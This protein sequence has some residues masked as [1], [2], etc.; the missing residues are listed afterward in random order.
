MFWI[1]V[2]C[3]GV[4]G[5]LADIILGEWSK[6]FSLSTWFASIPMYLV[7]MTGL[8]IVIRIG[9]TDGFQLTIAVLLVVLLNIAGL[10]LWDSY[11][12]SPLSVMQW[13]GVVLGLAAVACFE[14]GRA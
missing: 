4:I 5:A 14:F 1:L 3:M 13:L 10:A 8:G 9:S 11:R 7:F 6:S 12:G 2:G